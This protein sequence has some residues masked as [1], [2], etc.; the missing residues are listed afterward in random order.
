MF[1][2]AQSIKLYRVY[3]DARTASHHPVASSEQI[4]AQKKTLWTQLCKK[5]TNDKKIEKNTHTCCR[6]REKTEI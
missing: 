2:G 1:R 4:F 5:C 6:N 3:S